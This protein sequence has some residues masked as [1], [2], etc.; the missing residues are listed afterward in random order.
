MPRGQ[1]WVDSFQRSA[2]SG[3]TSAIKSH[4]SKNMRFE[5]RSIHPVIDDD[6]YKSSTISAQNWTALMGHK[7]AKASC[8][9]GQVSVGLHCSLTSA[10]SLSQALILHKYPV[11]QILSQHPLLRT[12]TMTENNLKEL[13]ITIKG[14]I[15]SSH[16]CFLLHFSLKICK[17]NMKCSSSD[18]LQKSPRSFLG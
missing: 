4:P 2:P 10:P 14:K 12:H 17:Q 18:T 3:S 11:H 9:S 7:H 8:G 15:L 5:R 1:R 13:P 16:S 6:G